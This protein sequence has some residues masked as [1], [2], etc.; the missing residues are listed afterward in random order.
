MDV[1]FGHSAD[2]I[3][4][5]SAPHSFINEGLGLR[6]VLVVGDSHFLPGA[7]ELLARQNVVVLRAD[8]P[9]QALAWVLDHRIPLGLAILDAAEPP[10]AYLDLAADLARLAPGFPVLYV[11]GQRQSVLR[12]SMEAECPECVLIAP[13]SQ[14]Q[15]EARVEQLMSRRCRTGSAGARL[16]PAA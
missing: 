6:A 10:A 2:Y 4:A 11:V 9:E 5:A 8:S 14:E 15:I 3:P 16:D 1:T 12:L 7:S 13:F